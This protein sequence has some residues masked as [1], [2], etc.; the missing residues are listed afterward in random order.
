MPTTPRLENRPEQHYA[1]VQITTT[2]AKLGADAPPL[3]G[4]VFEWLAMRNIPPDGPPFFRYLVIDMSGELT[5]DVGVPVATAISAGAVSA[6]A[7]FPR[8]PTPRLFTRAPTGSC[9]RPPISSPGPSKTESR[10]TNTPPTTARRGAH[11]SRPTSPIPRKSP[12]QT[13]GRPSSRSGPLRSW[14]RTDPLSTE[15]GSRLRRT[16]RDASDTA[17]HQ[18]FEREDGALMEQSGRNPWQPVAKGT[19]REPLKQAKTVATGC[20]QLLIGAHGKE[21]VG[22]SSPPEGFRLLPAQSPIP[23]SAS[24]A[25]P[26]LSVHRASTNVHRRSV[27]VIEHTTTCFRYR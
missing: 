19:P 5:L 10:G 8:A 2:M 1:A 20:D 18:G 24:A 21:G 23:L 27:Q 25:C 13:S 22:G 9:K 7:V 3:I 14:G 6:P 4:E 26:L 15:A 11:A 17:S 12:T 16:T